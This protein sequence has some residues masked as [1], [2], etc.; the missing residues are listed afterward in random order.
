MLTKIKT[1]ALK[2]H[3][4]LRH[5][6]SKRVAV[7][8]L[9][10]LVLLAVGVT[11]VLLTQKR[12]SVATKTAPPKQVVAPAPAPPKY[13]S[14][15][16]GL[17]LAHQADITIPV[18]AVMIEN[19]PDAR[20]Q[21]GLKSAGVVFEAIAEGG[22]TRFA[23]IYQGTMPA[24]IGPVRSVRPYYV[25]WIAPFDASIAHVGGSYNALQEVRNGSYRD[26]DQFFNGGSYWRATDRYAPHNV[27]TSGTNLDALMIKKG[28]TSSTFTGFTRVDPALTDA[29]KPQGAPATAI[30][31]SIS[32]Y[33]YDPSYVYDPTTKTYPRTLE[34][35]P[36]L[37]REAGQLAPSV[38]IV[39][40][41]PTVLGFEDGYR[42]QMTTIGTGTA[43][44]FQHGQVYQGTWSKTGQRDQLKFLGPDGKEI[45]LDRGQTWITAIPT[46][47][48]VQWH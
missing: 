46:E 3:H 5:K 6:G 12:P 28:Y 1:N 30:S 14:P 35:T 13:Y 2:I 29:Q 26:I 31:V 40:K 42:E 25:S 20:P 34:G 9:I 4:L 33:Y 32:G 43:Y 41:V 11:T 27:Y 15:L 36:Q 21:S 17:E 24:L 37:D 47:K 38:M 10:L 18:T 48:S 39:M 23:A 45:P 8:S 22:I 7:V 19:S 44:V 16:T